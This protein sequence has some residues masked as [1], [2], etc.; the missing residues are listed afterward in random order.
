[1][2]ATI[3]S[4]TRKTREGKQFTSYFGSI[5][6]KDGTADQVSVKFR[7]DVEIPKTFPCVLNFNK[8]DA[9]LSTGT[10]IKEIE[11]PDGDETVEYVET[12]TLWLTGYTSVE[13]YVDHSLDDYE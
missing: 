11:T 10:Y 2:K 4:K 7:Q 12:K 3:F 9:N 6:R 8:S 1:M 13:A 5:A